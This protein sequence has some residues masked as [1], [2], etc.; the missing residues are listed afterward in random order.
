[1]TASNDAIRR[2]DGVIYGPRDRNQ[3]ISRAVEPLPGTI[4]TAEATGLVTRR[5]FCKRL[6]TRTGSGSRG[7]L[8]D[9]KIVPGHAVM[10]AGGA[11]SAEPVS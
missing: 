9:L 3:G 11:V 7:S 6:F 5:E 1:L 10:L 2:P 8:D 4:G